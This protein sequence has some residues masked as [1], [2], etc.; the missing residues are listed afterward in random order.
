MKSSFPD[1]D[2]NVVAVPSNDLGVTRPAKQTVLVYHDSVL[3]IHADVSA[4]QAGSNSVMRLPRSANAINL[5]L[6]I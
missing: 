6:T 5:P 1:R 3:F 4:A 2:E